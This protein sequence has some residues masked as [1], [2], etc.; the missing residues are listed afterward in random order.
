MLFLYGGLNKKIREFENFQLVLK[1][2]VFHCSHWT[3]LFAEVLLPA[4]RNKLKYKAT[5]EVPVL[6]L[7]LL[8]S[9]V[10]LVSALKN[11]QF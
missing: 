10:K 1:M 8:N 5:L 4:N 6:C 11:C 2:M 3:M 7:Q 9:F